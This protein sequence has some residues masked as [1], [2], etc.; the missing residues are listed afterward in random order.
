VQDAIDLR[1][2]LIDVWAGVEHSV[3]DDATD[4]WVA[5]TSPCLH[6]SHRRTLWIFT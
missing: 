4:Q 5:Q 3:I 6:S 1:Q 2:H